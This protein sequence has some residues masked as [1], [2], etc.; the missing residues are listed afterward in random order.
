MGSWLGQNQE[1][2]GVGSVAEELER[3]PERRPIGLGHHENQFV[4][5]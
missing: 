2:V 4:L 1:V 5:G 3:G